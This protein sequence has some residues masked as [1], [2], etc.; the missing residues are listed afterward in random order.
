MAGKVRHKHVPQRTCV[1][2]RR[3]DSK[4]GLNR[5]VR[6]P[7][8]VRY[9]PTGKLPGRGAYLCDDPNCWQ[10]AIDR[11]VLAKSLKTSLTPAEIAALRETSAQFNEAAPSTTPSPAPES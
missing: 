10:R 5:I 8:G 11:G 6:T 1:V 2:C 9:D 3:T 7:D 4:R